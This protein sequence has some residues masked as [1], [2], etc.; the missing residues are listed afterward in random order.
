MNDDELRQ[1]LEELHRKIEDTDEVDEKGRELLSRLS[2]DIRNLLER[3]GHE[4]R[5]RGNSWVI[6]RLDESVRH[7]EVT[8]PNLTAALA[9]LLNILNNA[10]I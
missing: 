9:Q 10:G 4:E 5:L 8:H 7:F 1:L 2:V 3:A 6:G